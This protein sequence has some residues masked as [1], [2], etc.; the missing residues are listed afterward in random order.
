MRNPEHTFAAS[1]S[2]ATHILGMCA[3]SIIY[4][5]LRTLA[6]LTAVAL[7]FHLDLSVAR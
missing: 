6:M 4:G 5:V 7:V 3:F 2:L 1:I